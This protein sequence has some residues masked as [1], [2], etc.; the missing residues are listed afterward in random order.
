MDSRCGQPCGQPAPLKVKL[1]E[2]AL[3][4]HSCDTGVVHPE[5]FPDHTV[6]WISPAKEPARVQQLLGGCEEAAVQLLGGCEEAAVQLP[7]VCEEAAVRS[8]FWACSE[9]KRRSAKSSLH[10]R[11]SV[12]RYTPRRSVASHGQQVGRAAAG[13]VVF[14]AVRLLCV[15]PGPVGRGHGGN[16][17]LNIKRHCALYAAILGRY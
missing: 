10:R 17:D 1:K 2:A 13:G 7:G 6:V 15:R 9:Q 11:P 5:I 16:M 8:V 4:L 14:S 3:E 12:A